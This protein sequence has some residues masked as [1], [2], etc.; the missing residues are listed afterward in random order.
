MNIERWRHLESLFEELLDVPA[1]ERERFIERACGDNNDLK[2]ELKRL[3]AARSRAEA[4]QLLERPAWEGRAAVPAEGAGHDSDSSDP[5]IGK[6]VGDLYLIKRRL[7]AG[8]FGEVYLA[9]GNVGG[10]EAGRFVVKF[11]RHLEEDQRRRFQEEVRINAELK[12]E[13]IAQIYYWGEFEGRQFLV[14]DYV[15]GMNLGDFISRYSQNG[16]GLDLRKVGEITRQACAGIQYAHDCGIIHRDVKP[17]NIMIEETNGRLSVKVIDFGLAKSSD[18]ITRRPTEGVIGSFNYLAPE[19]I[20]PENF[21][22]PDARCD[23]YAMGLVIHEMLTGKIAITSS[24]I[25]KHSLFFKQLDYTPPPPGINRAV[26]RVVMRAI[27]KSPQ[28][29]QPTIGT[30]ASELNEALAQSE[31]PAQVKKAERSLRPAVLIALLSLLLLGA[32]GVGWNLLDSGQKTADP[33]TPSPTTR[34]TS[35]PSVPRLTSP[36]VSVLVKQNNAAS[37]EIIDVWNETNWN[38]RVFTSNDKLRLT[39]DPP[40]DG[41]IYLVQRGT[42]NDLTLLYPDKSVQFARDNTV[43]AKTPVIFPRATNGDPQWF[44]FDKVPGVE[45]IYMLFVKE[46]SAKLARLIEDELARN[47][48]NRNKIRQVVL[49]EGIEVLLRQAITQPP[50]NST[51]VA[52]INFRHA[53]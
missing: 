13:N 14:V 10:R 29:R 35:T 32:G 18:G 33:V 48:N 37:T 40:E 34:E 42:R 6:V 3:L 17:Q 49:D 52:L 28:E 9:V 44:Q 5:L 38:D 27:R 45:S 31:P 39:M 2:A 47:G 46:R 50:D 15:D 30:L 7:G 21:G 20:D 23:I 36:K 19:Q 51:T 22:H 24:G 8:G 12:H 41:F 26:D 53:N 1:E 4:R 25:E 11:A 43:R 16:K